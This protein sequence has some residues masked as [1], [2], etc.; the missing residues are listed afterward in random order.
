MSKNMVANGEHEKISIGRVLVS[1]STPPQHLLSQYVSNYNCPLFLEV[2]H[3]ILQPGVVLFLQFLEQD[4]GLAVAVFVWTRCVADLSKVFEEGFLHAL[5]HLEG[6]AG[7]FTP[8]LLLG[9]ALLAVHQLLQ[10]I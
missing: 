9:L 10:L 1:G 3:L 6:E 5:L 7:Q 4:V 8:H 2:L